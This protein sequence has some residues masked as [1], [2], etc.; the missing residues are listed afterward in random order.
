MTK[1]RQ[2]KAIR[3]LILGFI[4]LG[5]SYFTAGAQQYLDLS[6]GNS[7]INEYVEA[8]ENN[9][10][11]SIIFVFYDDGACAQC[12]ASMGEIYNIYEKYYSGEFGYFEINYAAEDNSGF[13]FDYQLNQPLSVVLVRI[14]D[15]LSRGYYKIDNPQQWVDDSWYFEKYLTTAI[16][17]FLVD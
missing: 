16:N 12:A 8:D 9:W 15:G 6:G 5:V 14:N 10:N 4:L 7:F 11:R 17:N 3:L 13:R 1:I 2:W